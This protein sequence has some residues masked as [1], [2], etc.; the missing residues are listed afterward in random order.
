MILIVSSS[1]DL[2]ALAICRAFDELNFQ[3]YLILATDEVILASDWKLSIGISGTR[4]IDI[5]FRHGDRAVD[6]SSVRVVWWR[7]PYISHRSSVSGECNE[8]SLLDYRIEQYHELILGLFHLCSP[9]LWV[10]DPTNTQRT[11]NKV[12]QLNQA[13]R[14]GFQL[15]PTIVSNSRD[16]VANFFKDNGGDIITKPLASSGRFLRTS[17]MPNPLDYSDD[18]F[19]QA[20]SI[21]QKCI[22]GT[23][24]L[25]LICFGNICFATLIESDQLDWRPAPKRAT[26]IQLDEIFEERVVNFTKTLGLEMGAFDFKKDRNGNWIFLEINPQGQFLFVEP[27]TGQNISTSFARYLIASHE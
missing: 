3:D 19:H 7:R 16:D 18:E 9:K 14:A 20:P 12:Y 17:R 2:H 6:W 13:A 21:Y 24:H 27:L 23:E 15:P 1:T 4:N 22:E 5:R 26:A 10:S 8:A 25:R 11:E